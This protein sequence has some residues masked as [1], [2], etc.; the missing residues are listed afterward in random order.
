[1]TLPPG[2][3]CSFLTALGILAVAA[4]NPLTLILAWSAIDLAE[5]VAMLRSTEGEEHSRGVVIAFASRVTGTVLVIWRQSHQHR[6]RS[7]NG[8]LHYNREYWES[9]F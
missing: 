2:Q 1:M 9:I 5:L 6:A 8:I 4:E 3:G 7:P